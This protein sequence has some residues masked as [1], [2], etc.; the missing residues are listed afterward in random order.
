MA[1][2]LFSPFVPEP[3]INYQTTFSSLWLASFT[4]HRAVCIII[5]P[6]Y[7]FLHTCYRQ[8]KKSPP[9]YRACC[10]RYSC[11]RCVI[12]PSL[13]GG[14]GEMKNSRSTKAGFASAGVGFK[15]SPFPVRGEFCLVAG[16]RAVLWCVLFSLRWK[17]YINPNTHLPAVGSTKP[18]A[19]SA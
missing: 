3:R 11:R 14:G 1:V 16:C 12:S 5:S 8:Q 6:K 15:L 17:K 9:L 18:P 10:C 13:G 7:S 4:F 19:H 2:L